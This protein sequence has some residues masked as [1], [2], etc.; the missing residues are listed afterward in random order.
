MSDHGA[1]LTLRLI[2]RLDEIERMAVAVEAFGAAHHLTDEVIFAFNLSLDEVV[3][4]VISYAFADVQDHT[5]DVRLRLDGD[6]LRAEISDDGRP[7]DP[8]E[9]PPPNIDAPIEERRIG[10]LGVYLVREMMDT[11]E[12]A[13]EGGRNVL[14]LSKRVG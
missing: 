6:V 10:G 9:V 11:V 1:E 13:R 12:Y 8:I 4:N 2:N 7:F 3:T 14:R 5:I